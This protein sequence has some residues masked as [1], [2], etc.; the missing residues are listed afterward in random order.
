MELWISGLLVVGLSVA[1]SLVAL[2][3]VKRMPGARDLR[4][5]NDIAGYYIA[6]VGTIYAVILAFMFYAVW[7]RFE[8]ANDMVD[9]EA[10]A[11]MDMYRLSSGLPDP[12]AKEMQM[13]LRKY[14]HAV[15]EREWPALQR[16]E[17]TAPLGE[18]ADGLLDIMVH[19]RPDTDREKA[20]FDVITARFMDMSKS[21]RDRMLKAESTLPPL[22]WGMMIFGTGITIGFSCLFGMKSY[23]LHALKTALLTATMTM[24]LFVIGALAQP[25]QG[26][27][28][29]RPTAFC[30]ALEQFDRLDQK[31][32]AVASH[33]GH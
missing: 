15:I 17:A 11:L 19:Q 8:A 20:L 27:I 25:F 12:L 2:R 29:I 30:M 21:R 14:A 7:S 31:W 28:S 23:S 10:N 4:D 22:L 1:A 5:T 9:Q 3:L 24:V 6:V 33:P 18:D 26:G 32:A 16:R 13:A